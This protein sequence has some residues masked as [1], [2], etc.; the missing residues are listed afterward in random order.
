MG[1][2]QGRM[3]NQGEGRLPAGFAE[4]RVEEGR[5]KV[6]GNRRNGS[7]EMLGA[8]GEVQHGNFLV[9]ECLLI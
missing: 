3:V 2:I 1:S 7:S 5:Q 8:W 6:T 4:S 9:T